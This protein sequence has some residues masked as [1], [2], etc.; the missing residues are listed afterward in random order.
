MDN[1]KEQIKAVKKLVDNIDQLTK[2]QK[3]VEE[4]AENICDNFC[5]F[6]GSG[7]DGNCIWCKTHNNECPLDE[8]LEEVG[9]K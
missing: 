9:L 2:I 8:I 4:L 5:K 3:T 6:S 1:V 7:S